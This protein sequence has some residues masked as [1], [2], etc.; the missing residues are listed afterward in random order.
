MEQLV[1]PT[2]IILIIFIYFGLLLGVS[3]FTGKGAD[4]Q[5]FFNADKKSPWFLVAFGMIGASLS[6]VTFI[7]LPGAVGAGGTN[8]DFS[9][10]QMV[11]GYLVGY[12][13]IALVLMPIYYRMGLTTIYTYLDD[14]FGKYSYLVGSLYFLLSRV[15]GASMRLF[16]VAIVFQRIVM[17]SFGIPFYMTVL[18]AIVL[19]W[20]Y[21]FKGGIK[22]IVITDTLQTLC[23]LLAVFLTIGAIGKALGSGGMIETFTMVKEGAYSQMFFFEDGWN[24]PNNFFKQF[25]S[26]ALIA[27]AMTGLDQ[28]MMQKNLT[29]KDLPSA[30]KNVLSFSV[31]LIFANLLFLALGALLYMYAV[32]QGI[33]VPSR[34]DQLYPMI[35]LNYLNPFI[36][37]L[38][39]LGLI[40]AAYS[41]ADSALT[42]LTTSFY[43][44]I[45]KYDQKE[46]S[47][48]DKRRTRMMVHVAFSVLIF[49]II[50]MV[51]AL[52]DDAIINKLF[53]A[54]GYTYG[55]ILGLFTFGIITKRK[56]LDV[57]TI[58]VCLLAPLLTFI[59]DTN[60]ADW[61]GGFK[62][63]S[64]L[65][66]LNA[67]LTFVGLM[68][69]SRKNG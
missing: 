34:T 67:L 23:M 14:R 69:I 58:P 45:L 46:H 55:P 36:G 47:E 2:T 8:M 35:A 50:L 4:N 33:D 31:V 12:A 20:I 13:L 5:T 42:S 51:N 18:I 57:W 53:I 44:D 63:G 7:S 3:Y 65:L 21:T 56:I 43:I 49:L 11:L 26:G 30:Q 38:F 39:V 19:I 41:S 52:D 54:A 68:L 64:T 16:L 27:T 60:S 10:M 61:L 29:C 22:T 24:D 66:G 9:Y 1:S 40:A 17:D 6:G 15:V 32:N 48:K 25:L 28:D 37:I 59:I 62:F